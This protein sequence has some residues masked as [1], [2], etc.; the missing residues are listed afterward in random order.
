MEAGA[1]APVL[2]DGKLVAPGLTAQAV[3]RRV[4]DEAR[5]S[6]LNLLRVN[7]FAVDTR[8]GAAAGRTAPLWHV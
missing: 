2:L 7:A 3:V 4:L 8:W 5:Q 6:G 1:G